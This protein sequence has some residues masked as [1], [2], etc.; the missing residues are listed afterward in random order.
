MCEIKDCFLIETG[1]WIDKKNKIFKRNE[2]LPSA[3]EN[4][5]RIKRNNSGIFKTAYSYNIENQNEAYLYGDFYLDFDS[6]DFEEVREDVI[7]AVSYLKIVFKID[8]N[9]NCNI[10]YSGN[11]GVHIIVPAIILGITPDKK[12]NEIFKEIAKAISEFTKN[13]T[14]DLRIYDNKRMFRMTNSIHESTNRYKIYLSLDELKNLTQEEIIKLASTP[15]EVPIKDVTLSNNAHKMF[16]IFKERAESAILKFKNIK[17]NGN[18]K[19]TPPCIAEILNNGAMNGKRNNTIA[20]L[21]SFYKAS[22]KDLDETIALIREWNN[23]KNSIPTSQAELI[24]TCRS[25]YLKDN[26]FGCTSIKSLYLCSKE[27]CNF[28]K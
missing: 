8:V 17:S 19:Y 3:F 7:M 20:I 10:F 12:L 14:L 5:V 13:K 16:L 4:A 23:I 15:R 21:A 26:Q 24:K 22:G 18:L 27:Q 6:Q 2:I 25:I 1:Y 11:K 28:R 9:K